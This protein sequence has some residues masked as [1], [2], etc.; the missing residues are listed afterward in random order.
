MPAL[1]QKRTFAPQKVMFALPPK[2]DMCGAARDV[3]Y[4]PEADIKSV[5]RLHF[6]SRTR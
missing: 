3:R 2:A 4:G 6:E 1:G 5:T